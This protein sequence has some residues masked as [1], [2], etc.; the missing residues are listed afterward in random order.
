MDNPFA[1]EP[2]NKDQT[3]PSGSADATPENP[4]VTSAA[5]VEAPVSP[6]VTPVPSTEPPSV[7]TDVTPDKAP[8]PV[9]TPAPAE[10]VESGSTDVT[11]DKDEDGDELLIENDG[12]VFW[13][14]QKVAWSIIKLALVV[15]AIGLLAWIIW[16]PVNNPL[17]EIHQNDV[18]VVQEKSRSA[19]ATPDKKK[20]DEGGVFDTVKNWFSKEEKKKSVS[21]K[22]SDFEKTSPDKSPD[23]TPEDIPAEA[24][25]MATALSKNYAYQM[26]MWADWMED[27]RQVEN[28]QVLSKSLYWAKRSEGYFDLTVEELLPSPD[29][30]DRA[31]RIDGTIQVLR[32]MINESRWL[33]LTL[34]DELNK[35]SAQSKAS[36]AS[37]LEHDRL[38]ADSIE[39]M[40]GDRSEF[41]LAE[42]SRFYQDFV[43]QNSKI[44][45][46]HFVLNRVVT[47]APLL[48]ELHDNLVA[49]RQVMID[50]VHVVGFPRDQFRLILTPTEWKGGG[51]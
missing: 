38:L 32:G 24:P 45:A 36:E 23:K 47:T 33:S 29:P 12:N 13:L 25:R 7:S 42:K 15:G 27:A 14:F 22:T 49:N 2:E 8:V 17:K 40:D 1:Q 28:E 9:A 18:E 43:A 44:N 20:S 21:V 4:A 30:I 41:L 51:K 35:A 39:V 10:E 6:S 34:N 50:R 26:A 31:R 5:P 37:M 3:A 48:Q 46:Y 19:K 11:P 16:R